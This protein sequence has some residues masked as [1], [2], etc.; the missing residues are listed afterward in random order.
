MEYFSALKSNETLIY[1]TDI[2]SMNE[3]MKTSCYI[4]EA[5]TK[6]HISQSSLKHIVVRTGNMKSNINI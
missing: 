4:N 3:T 6:A 2:C 1:A 5:T